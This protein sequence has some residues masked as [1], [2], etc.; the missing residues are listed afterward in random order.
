MLWSDVTLRDSRG[1]Y[2]ANVVD[3]HGCVLNSEN[4]IINSNSR[5]IVKII[6]P[7]KSAICPNSNL[8][9]SATST[10]H[11]LYWNNGQRSNKITITKGGWYIARSSTTG[12][13]MGADSIYIATL[14]IKS[15]DSPPDT[16]F[17]YGSLEKLTLTGPLGYDQYTW[18]GNT[19]SGITFDV[20]ERETTV[21]L[22][23]KD[24]NDCLIQR[25]IQVKDI[26]VELNIPNIFT[27]NSDTF[28]D[29]FFIENI[30]PKTRLKIYNRWG[31]EVYQS[32]E[33]KNNWN[34]SGLDDGLYFYKLENEY[35]KKVYNGWVQ[36]LR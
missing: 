33:Y 15:L 31:N 29:V 2:Y 1:V 32:Q 10:G 22:E 36:V 19:I 21:L 14:S 6:P 25:R 3:I 4:A 12:S 20:P 35:Y 28:N 5:P 9:L 18:N 24:T 17:C 8:L 16:T 30:L 11:D 27:P 26:C 23:V 7:E 13:C 34:A